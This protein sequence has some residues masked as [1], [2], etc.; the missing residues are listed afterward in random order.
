IHVS[1]I[2]TSVS[3]CHPGWSTV[4]HSLLSATSASQVQAIF[5]P[6]PPR[7]KRFSYL[8]LPS[9]WDY[10]HPPPHLANFC[11][12]SRD[13]G[14]TVLVSLELLTLDDLPTLASQSAEITGVNHCT[15]PIYL[16]LRQY[17]CHPGWSA[18]VGS[19]L[20]EPQLL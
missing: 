19:Q 11:I 3:L 13:Q 12:F 20:M 9:S 15:W 18:V 14:F 8:S 7:F 10:K 17:L 1:S 6:Q 2:N 4:A 16:F 5:L